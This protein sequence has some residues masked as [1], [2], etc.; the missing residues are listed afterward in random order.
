[1]NVPNFCKSNDSFQRKWTGGCLSQLIN[2]THT[3]E[4]PQPVL[5]NIR[6]ASNLVKYAKCS[7]IFTIFLI[8][9]FKCIRQ[10]LQSLAAL[11]PGEAHSGIY[12]QY[13]YIN[14]FLHWLVF[15]IFLV[16]PLWICKHPPYPFP[17]P[18]TECCAQ[19]YWAQRTM[20]YDQF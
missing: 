8:Y 3:K 13:C 15:K 17:I 4:L 12:H 18:H 1:M 9:L 10:Y 6:E 2:K 11:H 7:S 14:S 5:A 16:T 20:R 19:F